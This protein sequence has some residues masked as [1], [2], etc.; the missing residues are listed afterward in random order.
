[1]R[2][3]VLC[4]PLHANLTARVTETRKSEIGETLCSDSNICVWS[5]LRCDNK[6]CF[7]S[8]CFMRCQIEKKMI[9]VVFLISR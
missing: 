1:M 8:G 5:D 4:E 2:L 9:R 7:C 3:L 6:G